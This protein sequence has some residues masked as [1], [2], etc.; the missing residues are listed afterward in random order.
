MFRLFSSDESKE[1][2]SVGDNVPSKQP[3]ASEKRPLKL[4]NF[5]EL[6]WPHPIKSLRNYIFSLLISSYFDQTFAIE[7]FMNGAEQVIDIYIYICVCVC[8]C[9][10]ACVCV[11]VYIKIQ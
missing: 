1:S 10:C 7:T 9:I 4:M 11:C 8:A 5:R 3:G 6:I 2:D